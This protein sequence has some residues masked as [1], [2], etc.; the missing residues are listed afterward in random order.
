LTPLI[1][2]NANANE[3]TLCANEL[4]ST[5]RIKVKKTSAIWDH[6]KEVKL[7]NA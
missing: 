6:F 4:R 7:K 5:K 2:I 3:G 1:D